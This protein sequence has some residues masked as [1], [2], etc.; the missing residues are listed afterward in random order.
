M[1]E[2]QGIIQ[3]QADYHSLDLDFHTSCSQTV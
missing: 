3:E 1:A 2:V